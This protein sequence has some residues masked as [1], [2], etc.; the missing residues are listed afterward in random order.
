VSDAGDAG[1]M[2]KGDR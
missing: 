1:K 2:H